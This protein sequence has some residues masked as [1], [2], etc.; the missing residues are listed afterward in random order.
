MPSL[1]PNRLFALLVAVLLA[2]L[3]FGLAACGSSDDST[4]ASA[5]QIEVKITD[6][7]CDPTDLKATAGAA[8]ILVSNDDS[9]VNNEF[10]VLDGETIVGEEEN[11]TEGLSAEVSVDLEPGTYD[12]VCGNPGDREPTGK[13]TVNG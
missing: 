13:L 9:S 7:G 8:T 2:V 5:Q 6:E 4:S 10:E 11:V 12:I 1:G 3:T